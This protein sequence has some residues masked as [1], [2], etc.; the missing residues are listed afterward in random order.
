MSGQGIVTGGTSQVNFGLFTNYGTPIPE[1]ANVFTSVIAGV[2]SVIPATTDI[3]VEVS[4]NWNARRTIDD[5]E[6]QLLFD[7]ISIPS[8]IGLLQVEE[9]ADNAG[10]FSGTGSGQQ[11]PRTRKYYL[12]TGASG[13]H[14]I[15]LEFRNSAAGMPMVVGSNIWDI[16]VRVDGI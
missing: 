12:T 14:T 8:T 3:G 10:N 1:N 7:G 15:G 11:L 16:S 4:Y 9:P 6:V 5:C 13:T 2:T